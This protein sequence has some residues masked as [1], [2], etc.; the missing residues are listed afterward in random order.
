MPSKNKETME[1]VN[2]YSFM[3]LLAS[4]GQVPGRTSSPLNAMV[5]AGRVDTAWA[6]VTGAVDMMLDDSDFFDLMV[7][8]KQMQAEQH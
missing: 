3:G 8:A 5:T 7:D 4:E 6:A 1:M 2:G